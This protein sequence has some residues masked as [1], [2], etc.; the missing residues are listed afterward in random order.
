MI[1]FGRFQFLCHMLLKELLI[2]DQK[3]GNVQECV[4]TPGL[5]L[6]NY[7]LTWINNVELA[8]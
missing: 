7:N 5:F 8:E 1:G 3:F 2:L 6:M 4:K